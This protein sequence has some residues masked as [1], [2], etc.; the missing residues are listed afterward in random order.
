MERGWS[1]WP[2]TVAKF[3]RPMSTGHMSTLKED[4][5]LKSVATETITRMACA[6]LRT[7]KMTNWH[8]FRAGHYKKNCPR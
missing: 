5:M 3:K 4:G 6:S 8:L 1:G 2:V 7:P